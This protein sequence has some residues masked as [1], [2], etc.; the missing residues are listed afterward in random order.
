MKDRRHHNNKGK[1]QI[2]SHKTLKQVQRI[3][4][5]LGIPFSFLKLAKKRDKG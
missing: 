5:R 3:A 4:Q 1:Q 2:R